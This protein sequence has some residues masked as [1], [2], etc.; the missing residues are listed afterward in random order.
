V[1]RDQRPLQADFVYV[2]PPLWSQR[3][4][5]SGACP[6]FIS[7][8]RCQPTWLPHTRIEVHSPLVWRVQRTV[9][10]LLCDL[11]MMLYPSTVLFTRL[12]ER[13]T[14]ASERQARGRG[15]TREP[16]VTIAAASGARAGVQS[17][18]TVQGSTGPMR[19]LAFHDAAKQD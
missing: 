16:F 3:R 6:D 8:P 4:Q 17:S 2:F 9:Q 5:Q 14:S 11:E 1:S 18:A 15:S 7:V 12:A 10:D 19:T 13:W